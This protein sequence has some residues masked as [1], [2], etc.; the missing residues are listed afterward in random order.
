MSDV[1][2]INESEHLS[3]DSD[4]ATPDGI[5]S[6]SVDTVAAPG[7]LEEE[8]DIAA[9]Y[10]EELLDITDLDGDIEIDAR[11]GRAY[12]SVTSSEQGNLRLLSRPDTVTALQELTRIAVQT[13][14]GAFSRLILDIGGSRETR[15]AELALLVDKAVERIEAGAESASLPPMSSYERKLIHDVVAERGFTSQSEGEGRD[16]HT[17]ITRS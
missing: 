10:I 7:Q 1:T 8:G 6:P 14:T 16:R 2:E 15:E 5:E 9:D 3:S 4:T 12:L 13:K 17:V 11:G